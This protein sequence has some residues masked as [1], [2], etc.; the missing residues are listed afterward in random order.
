MRIQSSQPKAQRGCWTCKSRKIGC[1]RSLPCCENCLRTSRA[2]QGY[3]PRLVWRPESTIEPRHVR[4]QLPPFSASSTQVPQGHEMRFLIY[5]SKDMDLAAGRLNW[6]KALAG[7]LAG[8]R[9]TPMLHRPSTDQES[10]IFSYYIHVIAPMCSTTQSDNGL[11]QELPSVALSMYDAS[12]EALFYSMLAISGHHRWG[13]NAANTFKAK[14]VQALTRSLIHTNSHAQKS[15]PS[16]L[17]AVMMLCMHSVF[18]ADEGHFYIHLDGA[19]RVLQNVSLEYRQN[20]ITEFL[21]V[22]LMYY[23]VL[24]GFVHPLRQARGVYDDISLDRII[25]QDDS[26]I[27]LGLLGCSP[28]VFITIRRINILRA[29]ILFE[30]TDVPVPTD[31][32]EQRSALEAMLLSAEQHLSRDETTCLVHLN[33]A[34]AVAKA[35]LYR[36][37]ALLYLQRVVPVDGDENRRAAYV[38]QALSIMSGLTV[39]TSPWP[40]FIVAC[41]VTLEEQRLQILEVL[42]KMDTVRKIGN[43]HVTRT[44]VETIWKQQDLRAGVE[45]VG[46]WS[47]PSLDLS[48][49]WFA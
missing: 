15:T 32:I 40:C 23:D 8:P 5:D 34:E 16:Q 21:T 48:V 10:A 39:A 42:Y 12:T 30:Q 13:P 49:P 29:S 11:W 4:S 44:I 31:T 27:I 24:S 41:E 17:A 7:A 33:R 26:K 28:G 18:D 3:G 46:W 6:H 37:A 43:M 20:K 14:A 45:Q 35:E 9:C 36:L 25:S 38:Q 22:W 2:C 1:D 47:Y 19:R